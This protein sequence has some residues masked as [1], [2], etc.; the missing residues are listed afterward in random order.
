M[1]R[2]GEWA[3]TAR[4]TSATRSRNG[5]LSGPAASSSVAAPLD[6][7]PLTGEPLPLDLVNTILAA[8]HWQRRL[9]PSGPEPDVITTTE[10]QRLAW[11]AASQFLDLLDTQRERIRGCA[12]HECILYFQDNSR[13]GRRQWSSMATCGNRAKAPAPLPTNP[14]RAH[15]VNER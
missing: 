10:D 2:I 8:G 13:A 14:S 1:W 3:F 6:P 4:R 7:R 12:N 11:E 9:G 5:I 15:R